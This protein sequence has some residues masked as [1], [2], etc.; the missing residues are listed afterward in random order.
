[1]YYEFLFQNTSKLYL[2]VSSMANKMLQAQLQVALTKLDFVA[3]FS[4]VY[5]NSI[6]NANFLLLVFLYNKHIMSS[7]SPLSRTH[8][9]SE[10]TLSCGAQLRGLVGSQ[11]SRGPTVKDT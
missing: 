11:K 9:P 2:S 5:I 10:R 6:E 4:S 1:M 8:V 7:L 3:F